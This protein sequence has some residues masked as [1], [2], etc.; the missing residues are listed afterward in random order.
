MSFNVTPLKNG[1]LGPEQISFTLPA[2]LTNDLYQVILD[3]AGS[4]AI[5]DIAGNPLNGSGT[6]GSNFTWQ[7][8]VDNPAAVHIVFAGPASDVTEPDGGTR[9]RG[10]TRSR[11]SARRSP[12]RES[13]TS[14]PSCPVSTPRTSS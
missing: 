2:S 6:A 11:R 4:P 13:A 14:W 7:F 5:T 8:V 1:P 12:P 9:G 3:G 10:R